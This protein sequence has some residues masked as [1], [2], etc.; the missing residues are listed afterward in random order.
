MI[1]QL[2]G[3]SADCETRKK[4]NTVAAR[5][6]LHGNA[7]TRTL[8]CGRSV[9]FQRSVH[10]ALAGPTVSTHVAST[11][12]SC[13]RSRPRVKARS[14]TPAQQTRENRQLAVATHDGWPRGERLCVP[15]PAS[16][17]R[18]QR[19]TRT[20]M[21]STEGGQHGEGCGHGVDVKKHRR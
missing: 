16:H 12:R 11:A 14:L 9:P 3:A 17:G 7:G 19:D 21:A 15:Q 10:T 6:S 4:G 2:Q 13:A 20:L 8:A 5:W 18:P 1:T